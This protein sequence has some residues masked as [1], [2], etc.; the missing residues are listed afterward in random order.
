[1]IS[2]CIPVLVGNRLLGY[3]EELCHPGWGWTVSG[4]RYSHLP[5]SDQIDWLQ[6]PIIPEQRF[7]DDDSYS[8]LK[9]VLPW[10]NSSHLQ[11]TLS[12]VRS[13]WIYGVGNPVSY[14][15]GDRSRLGNAVSAIWKS[16]AFFLSRAEA[17]DVV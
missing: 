16:A 11:N 7:L 17:E 4:P 14:R 8:V 13:S 10:D 9:Q 15:H 1:M 5:F 2:Q 3:C 6:F 12:E